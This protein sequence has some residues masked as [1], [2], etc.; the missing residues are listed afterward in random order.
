METPDMF[1]RA[2][3]WAHG[4]EFGCPAGIQLRRVLAELTGPPRVGACTR[5]APLPL[6]WPGIREVTVSWP[7]LSPGIDA[8]VLIHPGPLTAEIR[9]RVR[10]GPCLVIV[11][12]DLRSAEQVGGQI[13]G[14]L[15]EVRTRLLAG[16]LHA[17]AR[18]Y[19]DHAATLTGIAGGPPAREMV[20]RVAVIGPDPASHRAVC[21]ALAGVDLVDDAEVDAVIAA[22]PPTGWTDGDAVTLADAARRTGRLISTA[23]LP[24]GVAGTVV[25]PG[26]SLTGTLHLA[27]SR[28]RTLPAVRPG[29][30]ERA[31]A[32]L[33]RRRLAHLDAELTRL[34]DW[35]REDGAAV[36]GELRDLAAG[37]GRTPG[38]SPDP[39]PVA[40]QAML[41]AAVT[42]V[43]VG[44]LTWPLH[45]AGAVILGCV[46]AAVTGWLRWRAGR[47]QAWLRWAEREGVHLRRHLAAPGMTGTGPGAWL[48][49]ELARVQD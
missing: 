18:R 13:A 16:E 19:P 45:P 30:W 48:R 33:E 43:A 3:D 38:P 39:L 29:G 11:A 4:R 46:V 31:V 14:Q 5:T 24:A 37:L 27:L 23:P 20:P 15:I 10:A 32:G 26:Q 1:I 7:A 35:A 34:L 42:G 6:G 22:A 40:G 9:A 44:R 17:L 8:A 36:A 41:M 25:R 21:A 49:R 2:A 47:R 12:P 28:P